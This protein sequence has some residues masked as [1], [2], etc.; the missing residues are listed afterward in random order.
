MGAVRLLRHRRTRR[1]R[2]SSWRAGA[3][4]RVVP[5]ALTGLLALLG[6]LG[7]AGVSSGPAFAQEA[8]GGAS[9]PWTALDGARQS[10]AAAGAEQADFVQTYLPAGFSS[11]E[12]ENGRIALHLPD[13]LR[14]DYAAPFPKSFLLCGDQVWSW[15]PAD[16]RGQTGTLD[17]KNQPGLDLL[18]LPVEQLGER[19]DAEIAPAEDGAAPDPVDRR[20]QVTVHLTPRP[21]L[22]ERTELT[23]ATLVVDTTT[24]RLVELSYRDR[25]GNRTKFVL[26]GYRPLDDTNLF[27][28]PDGI[29]WDEME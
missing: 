25:E 7:G 28:A 10:L 19:Y 18:L 14:W 12:E 22:A 24:E 23:G 6:L 16:R 9:S 27:K 4:P 17:R 20:G 1:S 11:G 8:P 26:S 21:D 2:R 5:V 15:N 29:T 13:C 3:R